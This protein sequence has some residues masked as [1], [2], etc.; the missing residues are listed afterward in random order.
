MKKCCIGLFAALTAPL[1]HTANGIYLTDYRATS[2]GLGGAEIAF[3]WQ[4]R[5]SEG[6]TNPALPSRRSTA[7]NESFS[8]HITPSRH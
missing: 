3:A 2:A 8:I 5:T 4:P 7:V 1:C 6:Y